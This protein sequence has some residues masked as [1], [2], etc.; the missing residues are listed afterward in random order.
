M[1]YGQQ[2]ELFYSAQVCWVR[3]VQQVAVVFRQPFEDFVIVPEMCSFVVF[4]GTCSIACGA[5]N[6]FYASEKGLYSSCVRA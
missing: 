5:V 1:G 3:N 2:R 4:Y 6:L